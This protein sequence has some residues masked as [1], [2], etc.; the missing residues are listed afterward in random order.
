VKSESELAEFA[1]AALAKLKKMPAKVRSFFG[2]PAL[3]YIS[4]L[5]A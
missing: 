2:D 3:R 1:S 4:A 5:M